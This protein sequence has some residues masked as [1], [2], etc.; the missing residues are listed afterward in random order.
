MNKYKHINQMNNKQIVRILLFIFSV[1]SFAGKMNA[2][3]SDSSRNKVLVQEASFE[4]VRINGKPFHFAGETWFN[5]TDSVELN[6]SSARIKV[7]GYY[8]G[9]CCMS[10]LKKRKSSN[11]PRLKYSFEDLLGLK[12]HLKGIDHTIVSDGQSTVLKGGPAEKV[13]LYEYLGGVPSVLKYDTIMKKVA[14]IEKI[15]KFDHDII[16]F[17]D[18]DK[19]GR[20][21]TIENL[22]EN[23]NWFAIA[24][25]IDKE[26]NVCRF[27]IIIVTAKGKNSFER[28]LPERPKEVFI[29]YND[30]EPD[31]YWGILNKDD[32]KCLKMSF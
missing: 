7:K 30:K 29:F 17:V 12:R 2:Q 31:T 5:L 32:I 3:S 18:S 23:K 6:D 14:N 9:T 15:E 27:D 16:V 25:V 13:R 1:M 22:D 21:L 20:F 26:M 24:Y 4:G 19:N 8:L 28:T 11:E 10:E